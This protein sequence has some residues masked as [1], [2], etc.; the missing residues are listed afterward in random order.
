MPWAA[1]EPRGSL[2]DD[3]PHHP[4]PLVRLT[5]EDVGARRGERGGHRL[6]LGAK[7]RIAISGIFITS[8]FFSKIYFQYLDFILMYESG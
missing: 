6:P 3:L 4:R 5:V 1:T 7:R 2:H 8:W